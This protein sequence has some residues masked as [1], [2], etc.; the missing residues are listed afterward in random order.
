MKTTISIVIVALVVALG[1]YALNREVD[2]KTEENRPNV[3]SLKAILMGSWVSLDDDKYVISFEGDKVKESYDSASVEESS[4][5]LTD[6][7]EGDYGDY[8]NKGLFLTKTSGEDVFKFRI[9]D[10]DDTT[11]EMVY[12]DGT[13]ELLRFGRL[14]Q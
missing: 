9:L 3:E 14:D 8:S 10:L 2:V 5:I 6:S 12:L 13:G 1:F 11:L 7:I 4:F